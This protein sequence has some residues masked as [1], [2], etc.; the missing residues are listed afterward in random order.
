MITEITRSYIRLK[1]G[2]K[3]ITVEGEAYAPGYGSPDFVAY[4]NS[5]QKWDA[6]DDSIVIDDETRELIIKF[7]TDEISKRQMTIEFE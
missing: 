7:L 4:T 1:L 3:T 5:I 2:D 6:P